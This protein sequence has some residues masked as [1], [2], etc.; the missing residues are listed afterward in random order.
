MLMQSGYKAAGWLGIING[1]KL[2]IDFSKL[3]FDE[4]F[5]LLLREIEAVRASLGADEINRTNSK[6]NHTL[7]VFH[8]QFNLYFSFD[9][10]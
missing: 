4:A 6:Y 7:S 10:E 1:S 8:F 3:P 5:N 2:H 9:N